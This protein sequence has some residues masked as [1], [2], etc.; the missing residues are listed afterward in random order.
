MKYS[1]GE[2]LKKAQD[3]CMIP[4]LL[5]KVI[6]ER[7]YHNSRCIITNDCIIVGAESLFTLIYFKRCNGTYVNAVGDELPGFAKKSQK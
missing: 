1:P 2:N 6:P 5:P 3:H 7:V 4:V